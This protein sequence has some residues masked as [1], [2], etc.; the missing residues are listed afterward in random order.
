MNKKRSPAKHDLR[1]VEE[2]CEAHLAEW[3]GKRAGSLGDLGCFLSI[4]IV[5]KNVGIL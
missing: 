3:K 1:I 4:L 5:L 2:T